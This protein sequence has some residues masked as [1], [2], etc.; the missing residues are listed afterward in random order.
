MD[1]CGVQ[2]R[3]K[4]FVGEIEY[5]CRHLELGVESWVSRKV[6]LGSMRL[7]TSDYACEESE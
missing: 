6:D 1:V 2:N 4:H 7:N 5:G 3:A